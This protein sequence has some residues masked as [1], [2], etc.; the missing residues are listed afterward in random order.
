MGVSEESG[1]LPK[2]SAAAAE[3]SRELPVLR[4]QLDEAKN[5][6]RISRSHLYKRIA[7]G[8]IKPQKDGARTYISRRELERYVEA[9]ECR[10][11]ESMLEDGRRG[12][13]FPSRGEGRESGKGEPHVD[14]GLK[15]PWR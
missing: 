3:R 10:A 14:R 5:I 13:V 8:A 6:L 15:R 2:P 7:E 9:C 1:G 11:P 12:E 4:F